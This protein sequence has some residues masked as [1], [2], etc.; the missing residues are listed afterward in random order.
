MCGCRI[1]LPVRCV[2]PPCRSSRRR[3]R[4]RRGAPPSASI[5]PSRLLPTPS[6]IPRCTRACTRVRTRAACARRRM[7]SFG[8]QPR[9][10]LPKATEYWRSRSPSEDSDKERRLRDRNESAETFWDGTKTV[11][12]RRIVCC[13]SIEW[14]DSVCWLGCRARPLSRSPRFSLLALLRPQKVME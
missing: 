6:N 5:Y 9:A 8:S 1:R 10:L 11:H 12:R 13:P 3:I 4:D 2:R 14:R 7:I